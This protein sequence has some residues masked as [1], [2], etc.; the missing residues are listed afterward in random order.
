M[1]A[2][3][4][5]NVSD[6]SE[7]DPVDRT[8]YVPSRA[9]ATLTASGAAHFIHDG[10]HDSLYV[11]L[12]IWSQAFGLSLVHVGI[13]KTAYS[14]AMALCQMPAGFLA[15]RF[16]QRGL[17]AGG[18]ILTALAYLTL[19]FA[20]GFAA[21]LVSL[22]AA[23]IGGGPQHPLSSSLVSGAYRHGPRRAALGIYNFAGDLGKVAVPAAVALIAGLYSWQSGTAIVG[24]LGLAAGLVIFAMLVRLGAGARPAAKPEQQVPA[25]TGGWGLIS[26][27]GF[28]A[29]SA[30]N[31]I[32]TAVTFGFLTF[33]P[34]L[35][36]EKGAP[37]ELLGV[38][39]ALVFGGGAAGKFL[40]GIL[41]ERLG[42]VRTIVVTEIA[43]GLGILALLPLPLLPALCLLPLIGV[44]LN[45]TSSV[46]YAS[47]A[48]FVRDERHSRAFAFVYTMGMG[49]GAV[50]P[51]LCGLISEMAGV[52][53]AL[54]A[55]GGL[56][57]LTLPICVVVSASLRRLAPAPV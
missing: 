55:M 30:L 53:A 5:A 21:L 7:T 35:M 15:E 49:A 54:A 39:V 4:R 40:C 13:L 56:V 57:F 28:A 9:R 14:G 31:L 41:A 32:D 16:G 23:G 8:G 12:P 18:T 51:P 29:I 17:L 19:G 47:V 43:T 36:V 26:P 20:G 44:A 25:D 22:L 45:G 33:M 10:L 50:S 38:A 46:L 2:T 6:T 27:R 1:A 42:I 48:D 24:A 34:F 37:V 11:L 3:T 52:P